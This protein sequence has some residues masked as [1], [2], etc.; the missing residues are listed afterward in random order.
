MR[1]QTCNDIPGSHLKN[2]IAHERFVT[3]A[4]RHQSL[5]TIG[6][7]QRSYANLSERALNGLALT[8]GRPLSA[9]GGVLLR[10]LMVAADNVASPAWPRSSVATVFRSTA[11][12]ASQAS[13][14]ST[15]P[16]VLAYGRV[17]ETGRGGFAARDLSQA[18]SRKT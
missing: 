4:C 14:V 6:A 13:S 1:G 16:S 7:C 9:V 17:V 2:P 3:L 10:P 8:Q 15:A 5:G 11:V 18:E 12:S